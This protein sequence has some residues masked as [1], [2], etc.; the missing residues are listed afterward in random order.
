MIYF[1]LKREK[2]RIDRKD[3]EDNFK[4]AI[5]SEKS[6]FDQL[7]IDLMENRHIL[8]LLK[9]LVTESRFPYKRKD[10]TEHNL[11]R[12]LLNLERKGLIKKIGR[13]EYDISDPLFKEYLKM[14]EE[15]VF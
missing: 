9:F 11:Y 7:W 13:G 2:N 6:Y 8:S 14:R 10:S 1:S 4:Q 15:S 3:V 5:L 12:L